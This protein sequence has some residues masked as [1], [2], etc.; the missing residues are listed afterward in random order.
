MCGR[1]TLTK[2]GSEIAEALGFETVPELGP[3]YNIAPTQEALIVRANPGD[4]EAVVA[5]WGFGGG[6]SG[7]LLINA[8]AETAGEKPAFR[9]AFRRRRCLVPAD[10]FYE[11]RSQGGQ[12][13][14]HHFAAADGRLLSFAGLWR[15]D[16]TAD[17]EPRP[18]FTILTVAANELVARVHARMPLILP[19]AARD[20]WLSEGASLDR[21]DDLLIPY[22]QA[23]MTSRAVSTAV[24]KVAN[25]SPSCLAPPEPPA[26]VQLDLLT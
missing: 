21:L 10:G 18:V 6:G 15:P 22:P 5:R 3:R 8:R 17:G 24:N 19:T 11:W 2:P 16:L 12:R 14:P 20:L 4:H 25:D 9:D 26:A 7:R 23:K 1:Y 13:Q